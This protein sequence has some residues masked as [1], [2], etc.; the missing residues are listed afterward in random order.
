MT[1]QDKK[2]TSIKSGLFLAKKYFKETIRPHKTLLKEFHF[3]KI[4]FI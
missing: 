1:Y 3:K 2:Y 4:N